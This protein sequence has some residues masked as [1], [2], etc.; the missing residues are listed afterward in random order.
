MNVFRSSLQNNALV[1]GYRWQHRL[2]VLFCHLQVI[3]SVW[4]PNRMSAG[5]LRMTSGPIDIFQLTILLTPVFGIWGIIIR[6]TGSFTVNRIICFQI[7]TYLYY[8]ICSSGHILTE[9]VCHWLP[10]ITAKVQ[11]QLRSWGICSRQ[12]STVACFLQ[13]LPFP[14]PFLN[15]PTAQHSLIIQSWTLHSLNNDGTCK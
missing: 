2:L 6:T 15:L 5:K 1:E 12:N 13:V 3:S 9:A 4:I 14:F 10:T 8:K 11:S 7:H